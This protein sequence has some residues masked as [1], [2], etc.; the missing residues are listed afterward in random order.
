MPPLVLGEYINVLYVL[1]VEA[2][3]RQRAL[4]VAQVSKACMSLCM[5]VHAMYKYYHVNT[6]VAPKRAALAEAAARLH[7]VTRN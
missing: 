4:C 5:W 6:G 2:V 1:N 7:A 3:M